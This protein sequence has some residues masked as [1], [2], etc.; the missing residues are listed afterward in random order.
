MTK[1][2]FILVV[3][4]SLLLFIGCAGDQ[5]SFNPNNKGIVFVMT[6]LGEV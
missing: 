5:P 2:K 3:S 4:L 6:F 1:L